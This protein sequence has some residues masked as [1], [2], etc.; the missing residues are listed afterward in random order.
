MKFPL[1]PIA[2]AFGLLASVVVGYS[3]DSEAL[4]QHGVPQEVKIDGTPPI[5]E[6]PG[7]AEVFETKTPSLADEIT[8]P[9]VKFSNLT[10]EQAVSRLQELADKAT[11]SGRSVKIRLKVD[12]EDAERAT[13]L[14]LA[15]DES[16]LSTV[17]RYIAEGASCR[18]IDEGDTLVIVPQ[19]ID[20]FIEVP[21]IAVAF[22]KAGVKGTFVLLDTDGAFRGHDETRAKTRYVPASTFKIPNSLI[23][24]DCGAVGSVDEILP[25]GGKPQFMKEWEHD[26]GLRD[27]IKISNVP[28]YQELARRIGLERMKAGV[29]K[30]DYGN[31]DIG[32]VVDQ[33]W[34]VGPLKI[35]AIEQVKFLRRLANEDLPAKPEAMAAVREITLLD[36]RDG[37]ELHGKTGYTGASLGVGWFV[38]WVKMGG[39]VYPF[40]LNIDM[41]SMDLAPKRVPLARECLEILGKFPLRSSRRGEL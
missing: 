30:L 22:D 31:K 20:Y 2:S 39:K 19:R 8:L 36:T 15:L 34:L 26:M 37:A 38:G 13:M 6:T 5:P 7:K 21:E 16:P 3:V 40:A 10:L 18:A 28:I 27:A 25:Y 4:L 23:G 1:F 17:A 24:L 11:P 33:F 9:E 12:Q 14:T 41:K 35:S 32:D 29:E